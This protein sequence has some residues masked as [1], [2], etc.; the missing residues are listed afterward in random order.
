[1]GSGMVG[2]GFGGSDVLVLVWVP[3]WVSGLVSG[4]VFAGSG[5][6]GAGS[7][8]PWVVVVWWFRRFQRGIG[9]HWLLPLFPSFAVGDTA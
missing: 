3:M 4:L 1:M 9:V 7:V 5:D 8:G 2:S 6:F